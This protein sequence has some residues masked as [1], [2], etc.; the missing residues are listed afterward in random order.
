[1]AS[2]R[3]PRSWNR[4]QGFPRVSKLGCPGGVGII[5]NSLIG[6]VPWMGERH[7]LL[8]SILWKRRMP[9]PGAPSDRWI[10]SWWTFFRQ[11]DILSSGVHLYSP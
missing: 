2:S 6:K 5:G 8:L 3:I 1:M 4:G 9:C 7:G 10:Y 11:E